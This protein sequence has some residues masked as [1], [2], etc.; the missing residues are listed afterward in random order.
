MFVGCRRKDDQFFYENKEVEEY[1]KKVR[2]K[3]EETHRRRR[4]EED[5][6]EEKCNVTVQ[7]RIEAMRN[8][9]SKHFSVDFGSGVERPRKEKN[10]RMMCEEKTRYAKGSSRKRTNGT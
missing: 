9:I 6:D 7:S 4:R 5:E 2:E 8:K 1:W 10:G 3:G